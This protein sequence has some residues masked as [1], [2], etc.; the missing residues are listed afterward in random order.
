MRDVFE[1][2]VSK[3]KLYKNSMLINFNIFCHVVVIYMNDDVKGV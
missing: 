1:K 2:S 3:Y